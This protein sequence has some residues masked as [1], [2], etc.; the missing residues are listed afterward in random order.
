LATVDETHPENIPTRN[1][2]PGLYLRNPLHLTIP[3]QTLPIRYEV[4][5][6]VYDREAGQRLAI[7]PGRTTFSLGSIWLLPAT[8]TSET[9]PVAQFGPHVTLHQPML[10]GETLTLTWKTSQ[11]LGPDQ[12]IYIHL[13]DA[14]G[15]LLGQLDGSPYGGLYP[16][17]N[18][19]AGQPITDR[20]SLPALANPAQLTTIAIGIYD[21]TTG[22]RLPATDFQGNPLPNKSFIIFATS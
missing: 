21:P 14:E 6:G 15:N 5:L 16:L 2:P 7:A 8:I 1:W 12:T 20:R 13:L 19:L 10:E 17:E 3:P 4:N 18:W 9:N 11:P 22:E